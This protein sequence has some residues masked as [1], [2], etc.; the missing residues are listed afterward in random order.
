MG[1]CSKVHL[2]E[3]RTSA[4]NILTTL[5]I[6]FANFSGRSSV[7][8]NKKHNEKSVLIGEYCKKEW[9]TK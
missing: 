6:D 1:V 9:H 5:A 7:H 2:E 8:D 3:D 4:M